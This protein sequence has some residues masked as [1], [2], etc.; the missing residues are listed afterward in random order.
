ME[1][2][3]GGGGRNLGIPSAAGNRTSALPCA[4]TNTELALGR[5]IRQSTAGIPHR[6][7]GGLPVT[8]RGR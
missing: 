8:P 6:R 7:R 5:Q 4:G 3:W 2:G 1:G